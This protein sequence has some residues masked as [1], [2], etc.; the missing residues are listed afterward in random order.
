MRRSCNRSSRRNLRRS[1]RHWS[2]KRLVLRYAQR[3]ET[4]SADVANE[5]DIDKQMDEMMSGGISIVSREKKLRIA[6]IIDSDP[7]AGIGGFGGGRVFIPLRVA[8]ELHV[9]QPND[10]QEFVRAGVRESRPTW[11]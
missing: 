1:R 9:A 10:V 5:K 3:Q 8:E 7:S 4:S 6:G 2:E 11:R